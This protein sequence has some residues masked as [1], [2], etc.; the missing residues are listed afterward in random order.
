MAQRYPRATIL[1]VSNSAPQREYILAEAARRGL[2]N[3]EVLTADMND[4]STDA[5]GSTA[6][7]RSRCSSTCATT[8]CC[9]SA[10]S[11][12]LA[13]GGRFFMHIF[14][15]RAVPYAFEDRGAD[16]W[17]SRYFFSGGMMPSAVAAAAFPAAPALRAAVVVER[18]CTTRRPPT[19]GS[20]TSMRSRARGAAHP[21][22]DVWRRPGARVAAALAHVLHGLRRAVGLS[23]RAGMVREPLPVRAA[24]AACEP[25]PCST[26]ATSSP[27]SSPGSPSSSA[28]RRA[29][30]GRR[31]AGAVVVAAVH[32][33]LR[34]DPLEL[35]LIGARGRRSA[36]WSTA[37]WPCT[38]AG[39][40]RGGLAGR[41]SRPSGC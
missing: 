28:R 33:A 3:V 26:S 1:A 13:P 21:R 16:D 4:F 39:A 20:P 30:R 2:A 7:C 25:A 36:C 17:M 32:L 5:S 40:L 18:R 38:R 34:R 23:R 22:G 31:A 15:H 8:R 41:L 37:R 35:K 12:W 19:P 14:V 27:I 11:R 10:I 24:G 29:A 6:W 9:S